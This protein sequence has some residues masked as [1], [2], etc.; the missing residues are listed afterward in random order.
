MS[1]PQVG[2]FDGNVRLHSVEAYDPRTNTWCQV[3]S[4]LTP[5][6]NF[7][8][9]VVD[10]RIFAVGGFNGFT[11]TYNVESYDHVV[12]QWTEACGMNIFRSALSCCVISGVPN[13]AE[14]TISREAL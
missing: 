2:G 1:F 14:Y 11:P 7:G 5:R 4:M 12:N 3:A 10:D 8:I 6:S 9:E 13:M